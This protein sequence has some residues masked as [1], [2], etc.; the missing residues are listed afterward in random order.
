MNEFELHDKLL[1][2]KIVFSDC[3]KPGPS[4]QEDKHNTFDV[5]DESGFAFTDSLIEVRTQMTMTI[6]YSSI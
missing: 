3:L 1:D 5:M 4:S 2:N 6:G